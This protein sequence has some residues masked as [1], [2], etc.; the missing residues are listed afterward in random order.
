MLEQGSGHE[1][2]IEAEIADRERIVAG[3]LPDDVEASAHLYG[4]RVRESVLEPRV[5]L[6]PRSLSAEQERMTMP[7][8]GRSDPGLWS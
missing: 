3:S 8:L 4:A 2:I 5:E 7:R 6:L 1:K